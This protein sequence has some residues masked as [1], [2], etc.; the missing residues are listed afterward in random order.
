MSEFDLLI[1]YCPVEDEPNVEIYVYFEYDNAAGQTINRNL[2]RFRR[3]NNIRVQ[4]SGLFGLGR[5]YRKDGTFRI[6]SEPTNESSPVFNH[7]DF[8]NS[9]THVGV[10][11]VDRGLFRADRIQI[12]TAACPKKCDRL[13]RFQFTPRGRVDYAW[14]KAMKAKMRRKRQ[15]QCPA[16]EC[17]NPCAQKNALE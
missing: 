2:G 7:A 10:Y 17:Q 16:I 1:E 14:A 9:T 11:Y 4:S 3:C 13:R 12:Q 5:N 8:P 6:N 15:R